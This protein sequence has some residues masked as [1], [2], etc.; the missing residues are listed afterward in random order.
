MIINL[1]NVLRLMVR[2][3]TNLRKGSVKTQVSGDIYLCVDEISSKMP[4]F[5][6]L[7]FIFKAKNVPN[8]SDIF[9]YAYF[10]FIVI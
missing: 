6:K 8:V 1:I 5:P 7:I 10:Y 9:V 3:Y 2:N 4:I